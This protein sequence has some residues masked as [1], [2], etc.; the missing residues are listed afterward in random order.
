MRGRP[1]VNP[2]SGAGGPDIK[3]EATGHL[4]PSPSDP[5]TASSATQSHR[6]RGH[7][8]GAD[9]CPLRPQVPTHGPRLCPAGGPEQ[10]P[11]RRPDGGERTWAGQVPGPRAGPAPPTPDAP[12]GPGP[13]TAP[14]PAG[15]ALG[16]SHQLHLC[17]RGHSPRPLQAALHLREGFWPKLLCH[18]GGW[19][20]PLRM[21]VQMWHHGW[22]LRAPSCL[23]G[24]AGA[25]EYEGPLHTAPR[26]LAQRA[27]QVLG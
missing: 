11:L 19:L 10:P 25:Q 26:M 24:S 13:P 3:D 22:S 1:R 5:S 2:A 6:G 9:F 4:L 14:P 16:M 21:G 8:R 20:R 18:L 12:R 15:S 7:W 27:G 23:T 17:W